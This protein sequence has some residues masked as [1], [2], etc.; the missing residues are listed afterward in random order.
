[1]LD[2][3]DEELEVIIAEDGAPRWAPGNAQQH[4]Y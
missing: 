2:S 1:M 4:R 3:P